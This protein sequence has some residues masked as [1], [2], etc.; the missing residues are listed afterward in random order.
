[1]HAD[2]KTHEVAN[3]YEITGRMSFIRYGIP[4]EDKP[5]H[6]CSE[7]LRGCIYFG[8]FSA[9]PEGMGTFVHN[10][11]VVE[12][13]VAKLALLEHLNSN[14]DNSVHRVLKEG[15]MDELTKLY[16]QTRLATGAH[17]SAELIRE[18]ERWAETEARKHR[19]DKQLR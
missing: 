11:I 9:E 8:F 6:G 1:M 12:R 16:C 2:G 3:E 10:L 19:S 14:E 15:T 17:Q 13:D 18:I 7:A 4:F 5:E